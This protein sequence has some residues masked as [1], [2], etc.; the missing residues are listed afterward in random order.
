MLLDVFFFCEMI[1]I[2]FT[3]QT[4]KSTEFA[5]EMPTDPS[6]YSKT[7]DLERK[8]STGNQQS[9]INWH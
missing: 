3:G 5:A 7:V 9:N 1:I 6:S 4:K 2:T 8:N